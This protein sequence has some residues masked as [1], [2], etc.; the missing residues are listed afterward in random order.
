MSWVAVPIVF[1][2]NYEVLLRILVCS[3]QSSAIWSVALGV[4]RS[5]EAATE[6]SEHWPTL[7]QSTG[8]EEVGI[9]CVLFSINGIIYQR[10]SPSPKVSQ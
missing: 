9:G 1:I 5:V 7:I 6:L 4:L 8:Q 3:V 2:P 10:D